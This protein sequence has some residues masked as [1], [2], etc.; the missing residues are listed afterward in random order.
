MAIQ[1]N[2]M[3]GFQTAIDEEISKVQQLLN[4]LHELK[5]C[6]DAQMYLT[7][8]E[9]SELLKCS[10]KEAQNYMNRPDFPKLEVGKGAK[11][12]KLAFLMYN[13]ERRTK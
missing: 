6:D 4:L 12:N 3:P 8:D 9:V 2:Q 10:L 5:A 11:V 7:S 13:M 1:M